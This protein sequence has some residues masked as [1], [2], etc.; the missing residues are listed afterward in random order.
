MLGGIAVIDTQL[1]RRAFLRSASGAAK[2]SI[3][4]LSLPAILVSCERSKQANLR[5]EEFS[6]LTEEEAQEFHAIAARIIPTDETPGASEAGVIYFIDNVLNDDREAEHE[7]LRLGLRELQIGAALNYSAAYFHELEPEQQDQLLTEIEDTPFFATIRFLTI[8]G[9]F[10]LPEYGG[11]RD[12]I[13]Y[14]LIGFEDR[15]AWLPPYGFYD[16]D[17]VERGE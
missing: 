5:N 14:E 7:T 6:L 8:A 15:H 9:M 10:S 1:S 11:N 3:I 4:V 16:A 13:G 12:K 2:G 17:Y